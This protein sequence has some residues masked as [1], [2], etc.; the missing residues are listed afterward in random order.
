MAPLR[1]SQRAIPSPSV[2][3]VPT[4]RTSISGLNVSS[5]LFSTSVIALASIW[6]TYASPPCD[7]VPSVLRI[8]SS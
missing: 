6:V 7:A 4:S 8:A 3:T 5:C 2:M 1:P